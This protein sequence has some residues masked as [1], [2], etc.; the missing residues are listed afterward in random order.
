MSIAF[1]CERCGKT[2]QTDASNAGKKARCKQCGH[3]F[4]IPRPKA[5]PGTSTPLATLGA[6]DVDP[7]RSRPHAKARQRPDSETPQG[8]DVPGPVEDP[9]GLEELAGDSALAA[10]E[11]SPTLSRSSMRTQKNAPSLPMPDWEQLV[12]EGPKFVLLG[13]IGLFLLLGLFAGV[14]QS[15]R[16]FFP[17]GMWWL[18][19]VL[20]D[21]VVLGLALVALREGV[22]WGVAWLLPWAFDALFA[23][24]VIKPQARFALY[25][26]YA[27]FVIYYLISRWKHTSRWF[28]VGM[29]NAILFGIAMAGVPELRQRYVAY[30]QQQA[31]E[32]ARMTEKAGADGKTYP[33]IT[34]EVTGL[35]DRETVEDFS[36]QIVKLSKA[37]MS[38][39]APAEGAPRNFLIY[40]DVEPKE[41]A[42]EITWAKVTGVEGRMIRVAASSLTGGQS[43][44]PESDFIGCVL[45][46]L[47]APRS[48]RSREAL[49]RLKR[50]PPDPARRAEVA[51]AIERVLK[52]DDGF[53]QIAALEALS[54]WGDKQ[55]TPAI[56]AVL[57]SDN[58]FVASAALRALA[59]LKDTA[60]AEEVAGYLAIE[61]YRGD[62]GKTLIALGKPAE[63]PVIKY[64]NHPNSAT[65]KRA[66]DVLAVIGTTACVPALEAMLTRPGEHDNEAAL[67]RQIIERVHDASASGPEEGSTSDP[68][69]VRDPRNPFVPKKRQ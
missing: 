44:P 37:G 36:Q 25:G 56:L 34:V 53:K 48:S 69:K 22:V 35:S 60:A 17:T 6:A 16:A 8:R 9:Y 21:V 59:M 4:V 55:N 12:D 32:R 19:W 29:A 24:G 27:I 3:A 52:V 33:P 26:P 66:L 28:G 10:A 13:M 18:Y 38:S 57:R 43:R 14:S 62:A 67:A 40:S 30:Q 2:F 11:P 51:S 65:R 63:P 31:A 47:K 64:L 54:L 46:D 41:L 23:M 15:G 5:G 1:R 49:D 42:R 50:S 20:C 39:P 58:V 61:Q 7:A 68:P 45:Y